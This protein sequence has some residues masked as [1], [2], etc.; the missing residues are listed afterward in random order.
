VCDLANR[1]R[2]R[3]AKAYGVEIIDLRNIFVC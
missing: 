2:E 3:F 1:M